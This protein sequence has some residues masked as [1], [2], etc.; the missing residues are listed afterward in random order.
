MGAWAWLIPLFPLAGYGILIAWGRRLGDRSPLV[1]VGAMLLATLTALAVFLEQLRGVDP[2]VWRTVWAVGGDRVITAGYTVD[3]L[4]ATMALMVTVVGTLIFL[5]SIGYMRGDPYYSRFF[6]FLSLFCAGMLTTVL[7]NSFLVL[8]LGWE[9]IGLCSYLLIGFYFRRR[10]ANMAQMKAFLTTRVGD[11]FMLVGIMLLFAQ[12]GTVDYQ[13][14]FEALAHGKAWSPAAVTLFGLPVPLAVLGALLIFGGSV[15]K[16]GQVPLHVWLPDAMEGPTPVSALIHAA[17]MV[18][19]GVY[20]VARTYPLFFYTPGHVA[21][22]AV[23]WVGAIT[24]L[25]AALMAVA[26]DDIKRIL[27]YSTISQLGFMMAG[28]GVLGYTAGFFHLLTHAFF[29]ALLFLGAGS[30]I[31][32]VRTNNIKEMGGLW[33]KM[34]VTFG[35]FLIG[36][37]AL[38]GIFPFAGFWS[39]DEILLEAYH[40][41]PAVYWVLTVASFLTAFY[42]TRLVAYAFFGSF[43]GPAHPEP[44]PWL[45][46]DYVRAGVRGPHHGHGSHATVPHESPPVMTVPLVVLAAFS[47]GVG[48]VGAPGTGP[49]GGSWFH[50]FIEFEGFRE[51]EIHAPGFSWAVALRGLGV[52]LAGILVAW[53]MYGG[54]R[55]YSEQVRDWMPWL[56]AFLRDRMYFDAFYGWLFVQGG[57]ALARLLRAFDTYVVDGI[58]NA[59]GYLTVLIARVDRVIDTYV[60]DGLVNLVGIVTR[61]LGS[62]LRYIQTGRAY[63]YILLATLGVVLIVVWTLWRL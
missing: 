3:R 57:L 38:A 18:A 15:G 6:A 13:E 58:V 7:A 31:H 52:A 21:L 47:A 12:F 5:Y 30:V 26:Q 8:L 24:A 27:A 40:H 10:S 59:V 2:Y 43:R 20:L 51:A 60:V 62:V 28:L 41:N 44:D 25:L 55:R 61:W 63:N 11:T 37:L 23:A 48:F 1:A 46:E 49:E 42:M 53:G 39:K 4:S 14:I 35:T 56:V 50:R 32:A 36:Y 19:A 45:E 22:E 29:K 34:P 33:R 17:T 16:S 9:I 54:R